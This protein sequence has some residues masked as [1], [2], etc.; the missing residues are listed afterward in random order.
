MAG[1]AWSKRN[2]GSAANELGDCALFCPDGNPFSRAIP[3]GVT[4]IESSTGSRIEHGA[5]VYWGAGTGRL[6]LGTVVRSR[7]ELTG[8]EC[9]RRDSRRGVFVVRER[10]PG[11]PPKRAPSRLVPGCLYHGRICIWHSARGGDRS[12]G[13]YLHQANA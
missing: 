5:G 11:A 13:L 7:V 3:V 9:F 10:R 12:Y 8:N 1:P 6:P 2:S 4:T